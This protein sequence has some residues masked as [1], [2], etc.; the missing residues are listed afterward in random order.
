M[1][2]YQIAK[3]LYENGEYTQKEISRRVNLSPTSVS[4]SLQRLERKEIVEQTASGFVFHTD[5]GEE[6]LEKIRPRS[7]EELRD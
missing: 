3:L 1:G 4:E 5:A 6:E 7:I 2:Q